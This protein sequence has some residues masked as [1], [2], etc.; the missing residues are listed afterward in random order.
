MEAQLSESL[1]TE[2]KGERFTL[3]DPPQFPEKPIKPNRQAIMFLGF[4]FAIGGGLGIVILR[5]NLSDTI[6]NTKELEQLTNIAPL[7]GI[8]FIENTPAPDNEQQAHKT[9]KGVFI[10]AIVL[11]CIVSVLLAAHFFYKP[12]DV[13]WFVL[14]R[15]FGL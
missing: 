3:I 6:K 13:T 15:K 2:R 1:E 4:I 10:G 5:D 9:Y 11:V 14:L 12:L 7:V 8:S